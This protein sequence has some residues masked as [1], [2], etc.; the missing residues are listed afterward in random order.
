MQL[1]EDK[2]HAYC[3]VLTVLV[4]EKKQNKQ[5]KKD[6]HMIYLYI[7]KIHITNTMRIMH[8]F[9]HMKNKFNIKGKKT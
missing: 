2:I 7:L 3:T 6:I 4:Y 5:T 1:Q 9:C 8:Y